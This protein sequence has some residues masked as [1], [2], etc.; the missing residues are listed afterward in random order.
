MAKTKQLGAVEPEFNEK[1]VEYSKLI[2][3]S[4]TDLIEELFYKETEDKVLNNEFIA[5]DVPYFINFVELLN[6]GTVKATTKRPTKDLEQVVIIK[7]II[8]N[9]DSFNKEFRT[10]CSNNNPEE[11]LGIY[12]YNKF[13]FNEVKVKD[14]NLFQY[15]LLFKYNSGTEELVIELTSVE[16]VIYLVDVDKTSE[17]ISEL[18]EFNKVF[19]EAIDRVKE[20]PE[21]A[22]FKDVLTFDKT[23]INIGTYLTSILVIE[24]LSYAKGLSYGFLETNLEQYEKLTENSKTSDLILIKDIVEDPENNTINLITF[25]DNEGAVNNGRKRS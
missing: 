18:V 4:K 15:Y 19:I 23:F 2:G 13:V 7:R 22:T 14:S 5:I 20:A 1:L 10:F 12:S 25:N 24:P 3:I 11:H 9:L 21:E 16:D 17:V 8:N 6:N